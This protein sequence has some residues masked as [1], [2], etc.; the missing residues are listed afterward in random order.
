MS[1][2]R[3]QPITQ[4]ARTKAFFLWSSWCIS[5]KDKYLNI[6]HITTNSPPFAFKTIFA[7]LHVAVWHGASMNLHEETQTGNIS[8]NRHG[9]YYYD[10]TK[11]PPQLEIPTMWMNMCLWVFYKG[12]GRHF[13]INCQHFNDIGGKIPNSPKLSGKT[14]SEL[15]HIQQGICSSKTCTPP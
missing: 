5:T 8:S 2:F 15:G 12:W 10:P 11:T 6:T 3:I 14:Q 4:L 13:P 7:N 9:T 1:Y